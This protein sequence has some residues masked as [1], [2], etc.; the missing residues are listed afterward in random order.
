MYAIIED[1]HGDELMRYT[2]APD[3][4]MDAD[5]YAHAYA[6]SDNEIEECRYGGDFDVVFRDDL[7][8]PVKCWNRTS[9]AFMGV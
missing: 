1:E 2:L 6:G 3:D 7:D 8:N 9:Y 5:F 4:I